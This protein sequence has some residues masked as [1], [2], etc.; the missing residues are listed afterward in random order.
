MSA[1]E[2]SHQHITNFH[3]PCFV[4]QA[5]PQHILHQFLFTYCVPHHGLIHYIST[6]QVFCLPKLEHGYYGRTHTYQEMESSN[7][8]YLKFSRCN[9]NS[10]HTSVSTINS[11]TCAPADNRGTVQYIRAVDG[12]SQS[13]ESLP[14]VTVPVG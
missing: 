5:Y 4:I 11:Q 14:R 10:H 9:H 1:N 2:S 12:V 7:L 3:H 6:L 8:L 13:V